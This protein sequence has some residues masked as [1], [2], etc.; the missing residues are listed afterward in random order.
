MSS[1]NDTND[2]SKQS[3]LPKPSLDEV[4]QQM[5]EFDTLADKLFLRIEGLEMQ[6]SNLIKAKIKAEKELAEFKLQLSNAH[7]VPGPKGSP[8]MKGDKGSP[9][10]KGDKGSP[11]KK[12][13]RGP[14]GE[15][16]EKGGFLFGCIAK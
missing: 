7:S 10:M 2:A 9:G 14:R 1:A 8:G 11:G 13:D 6:V 4:H 3:P 5:V 15:S 16:F 12:G